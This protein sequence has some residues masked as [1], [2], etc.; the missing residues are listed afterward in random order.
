MFRHI[1]IHHC[2]FVTQQF[3]HRLSAVVHDQVHEHLNA[4]VKEDGGIIGITENDAELRKWI[5]A[6]SEMARL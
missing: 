1:H 6:G 2:Y 3:K 4:M 5:V